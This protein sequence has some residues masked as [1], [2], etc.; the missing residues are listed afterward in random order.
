LHNKKTGGKEG[1]QSTG[2]AYKASY[3]SPVSI[4]P[5][6]FFISPG[7]VSLDEAMDEMVEGI[8]ITDV[9]GLHAGLN[10][11]SGDF[12]L[13][14]TGFVIYEGKKTNAVHQITIAGN[15]FEML[16]DIKIICSDLKFIMPGS[17]HIGSPSILIGKLDISGE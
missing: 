12:S 5:T 17:G 13:S 14:A 11:I 9:Q 10:A 15:F 2:N 1:V 4:A 6:N 8:Y 7:S 3:K 16:M